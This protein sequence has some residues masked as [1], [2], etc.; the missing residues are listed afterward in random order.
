MNDI[1]IKMAPLITIACIGNIF[2][3]IGLFKK[4][5]GELLLKLVFYLSLPPLVLL[6]ILKI[7][8]TV[9]YIYLPLIAVVVHC[10]TFFTSFNIGKLLHLPRKTLGV[11]IVGSMIINTGFNLPFVIAAFGEKGLAIIS[12][13]DFGSATIVLTF[14]YYIAC[15][16]G[17]Q[18]VESKLI[19]RKL[20]LAP[21]LWALMGGIILNF[22]NITL[23]PLIVSISQTIGNLTI[24]LLMLTLG[25]YFSFS[26]IR[27]KALLSVII[28]RM[29]LGFLIGLTCSYL[30]QLDGLIRTVTIIATSAPVGYNTLT[31]TA[32]EK[33]DMDFAA[34]L[35]S[36]SVLI[37]FIF[38]PLL[39][40]FL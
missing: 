3:R 12:I 23:S 37:G 4:D 28:I 40:M 31:F 1:I 32:L 8:L 35:V 25:F 11:F 39:I 30:F 38:V 36:F 18:K 13:F 34:S 10:I 33:L 26:V 29:A 21:P 20:L 17:N 24:P 2:K 6:S 22:A 7:E 19:I 27:F 15:Y 9:T 5:D 14:V 16:Y